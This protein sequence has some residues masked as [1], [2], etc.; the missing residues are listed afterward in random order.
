MKDPE[1]KLKRIDIGMKLF[2]LTKCFRG[3]GVRKIPGLGRI[4]DYINKKYF[5]FNR[6]VLTKVLGSK[7]YVDGRDK[8]ISGHLIWRGVQS[9]ILSAEKHS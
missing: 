2:N 5:D 3:W 6:V 1:N 8:S 7:M 9:A 4:A